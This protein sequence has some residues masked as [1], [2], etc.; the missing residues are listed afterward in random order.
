MIVDSSYPWLE[1]EGS[2]VLNEH[3]VMQPVAP[4]FNVQQELRTE[5]KWTSIEEQARGAQVVNDCASFCGVRAVMVV[6]DMLGWFRQ[7]PRHLA[8]RWMA[9]INCM[10]LSAIDASLGMGQ[11]DSAD[12]AER[13]SLILANIIL[14]RLDTQFDRAFQ[15]CQKYWCKQFRLYRI[16]RQAIFGMDARQTRGY[17]FIPF[18]DLFP[19]LTLEHKRKW[20]DRVSNLFIRYS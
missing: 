19:L 14:Y 8:H 18:V 11:S 16:K 20:S 4:N 2:V 5:V 3:N 9:I 6:Y 1:M 12:W 10:D 7:L 15:D 17:C 13:I